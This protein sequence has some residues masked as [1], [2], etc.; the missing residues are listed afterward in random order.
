MNIWTIYTLSWCTCGLTSTMIQL[1]S[2]VVRPWFGLSVIDIAEL[3]RDAFETMPEFC[4]D[5]TA[6][7]KEASH[8]LTSFSQSGPSLFVWAGYASKEILFSVENT[9]LINAHLKNYNI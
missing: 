4:G 6:I 8:S 9:C 2:V 3:P 1:C 5:S 7:V